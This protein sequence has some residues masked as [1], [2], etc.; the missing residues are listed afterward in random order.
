MASC[1]AP[2]VETRVVVPEVPADLRAPCL[3]A[4][5]DYATLKDVALILT[6][7][8]E[9]LDCANGRLAAIDEILTAAEAKAGAR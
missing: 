9:A 7:H 4:A 8:V 2:P 6:D 5:R 3:V 1:S